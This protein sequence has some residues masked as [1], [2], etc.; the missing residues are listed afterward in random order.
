LSTPL[1]DYHLVVASELIVTD[2]VYS[3]VGDANRG[4]Y[5]ARGMN[6]FRPYRDLPQVN[7]SYYELPADVLEDA[8]KCAI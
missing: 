4:D 6:E 5:A 8:E 7:M 1:A 3:K 2:V